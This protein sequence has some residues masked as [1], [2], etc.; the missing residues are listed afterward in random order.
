MSTAAAT[1]GTLPAVQETE[2]Q[3]PTP[4]TVGEAN[5]GGALVPAPGGGDGGGAGGSGGLVQVLP[6]QQIFAQPAVRR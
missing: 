5:G 1:P 6:L 3:F 2:A 4:A